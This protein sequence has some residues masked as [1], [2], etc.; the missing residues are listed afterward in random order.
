[1]KPVTDALRSI[2]EDAMTAI[3]D[4]R[5]ALALGAGIDALSCGIAASRSGKALVA[6]SFRLDGKPPG[7]DFR[8]AETNANQF[9]WGFREVLLPF[10]EEALVLDCVFLTK[11]LGLRKKTAVECAW[12][13]LYLLRSVAEKTVV[14]G[15]CAD[16]YF[17]VS[18]RAMIRY[19]NDPTLD[20]FRASLFGNADYAQVPALR[21]LAS[22]LGKEFVAPYRDPRILP[23]FTG[24]SWRDLNYPRQ[25]QVVRDL[26]PDE[27]ARVR[28]GNH[29]NYQCGDSGIREHFTSLLQGPLN[30]AGHKS[31]VRV[32]NALCSGRVGA[33]LEESARD[34]W[35][36][37]E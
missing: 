16:G 10:D 13:F 14:A 11:A 34:R 27:F 35:S 28:I 24:T 37:Y 4:E 23:L 2:L 29:L 3:P 25:K 5:V 6:Y 30:V 19:R 33:E 22:K 20:A 9:G 17:G 7:I 21:S 32:Y 26:Y 31:V 8:G 15:T 18:K 12:P 36:C 1:M